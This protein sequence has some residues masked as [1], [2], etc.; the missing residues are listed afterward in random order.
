MA[1]SGGER[2]IEVGGHVVVYDAQGEFRRRQLLCSTH[3][4]KRV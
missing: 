2:W 3:L 4:A 1:L